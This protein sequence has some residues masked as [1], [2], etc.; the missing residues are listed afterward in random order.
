MEWDLQRRR[1]SAFCIYS[2]KL[3]FF[4]P[5]VWVASVSRADS[6]CKWA[7]A[8]VE[9]SAPPAAAPPLISITDAALKN[10]KRLREDAGNDKLLL[11]MGVR[12]GGCSGIL[13][14]PFSCSRHSMLQHLQQILHTVALDT[15]PVFTPRCS[16]LPISLLMAQRQTSSGLR[17]MDHLLTYICV[18]SIMSCRH[19]LPHGL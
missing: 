17:E 9:T 7:F 6:R 15:P 1:C 5:Q 19:E 11:R 3:Y 2:V 4:G 16:K 12:S 10:L 13:F 18:I 8:A 14:G